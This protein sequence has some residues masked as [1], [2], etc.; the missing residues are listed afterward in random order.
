[1]VAPYNNILIM[2]RVI[3]ESANKKNVDVVISVRSIS[4]SFRKLMFWLI[5]SP[6]PNEVHFIS[7]TLLAQILAAYCA[8]TTPSVRAITRKLQMTRH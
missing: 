4:N 5:N 2:S 6:L 1:M 7:G 8:T 3:Y